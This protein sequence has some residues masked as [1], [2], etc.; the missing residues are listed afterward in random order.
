MS[1]QLLSACRADLPPGFAYFREDDKH[2]HFIASSAD[3]PEVLVLSFTTRH[4]FVDRSCEIQPGEHPFVTR[5][6]AVSYQHA[7]VVTTQSVVDALNT[8]VLTPQPPLSAE[9]MVRVWEGASIS[10]ELPLRA[11]LLLG[12]QDLIEP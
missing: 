5:S 4:R 3:E 6:T 1:R 7:A 9:L 8:G 12:E 2:L 11:R 10:R